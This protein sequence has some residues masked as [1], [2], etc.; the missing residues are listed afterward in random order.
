MQDDGVI[1][2]W[3]TTTT[4]GVIC[5]LGLVFPFAETLPFS[6]ALNWFG[7]IIW[8]F[9]DVFK[10]LDSYETWLKNTH[11]ELRHIFDFKRKKL[12][13]NIFFI[14]YINP[15]T[16][17]PVECS[18]DQ[19]LYLCLG[20]DVCTRGDE[21]HPPGNPSWTACGEARALYDRGHHGESM[22]LPKDK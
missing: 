20:V 1:A 17:T 21:L 7:S 15:I 10:Q 14:N 4:P 22:I 12:F 8:T 6:L 5:L 9:T 18:K 16:L 11:G 19:T 2:T 3:S 13:C